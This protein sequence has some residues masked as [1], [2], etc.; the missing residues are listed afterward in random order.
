MTRVERAIA[1]EMFDPDSA[2]PKA[3]VRAAMRALGV[4]ADYVKNMY[5]N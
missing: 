4:D 1:P 2:D 3:L 5:R